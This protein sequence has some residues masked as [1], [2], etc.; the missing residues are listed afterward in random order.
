M[1]ITLNVPISISGDRELVGG[2]NESLLKH[3]FSKVLQPASINLVALDASVGSGNYTVL[4]AEGSSIGNVADTPVFGTN[5]TMSSNDELYIADT[6]ILKELWVHIITA[7]VFTADGIDLFDSTNGV[8]FNR[9][10]TGVVDHTDAFRNVGW[11]DIT[12]T[13]PA[14]AGVALALV[15]TSPDP[16]L[17]TARPWYKIKLRNFTTVTTAPVLARITPIFIDAEQKYADLSGLAGFSIT[18]YAG[19]PLIGLTFFPVVGDEVIITFANPARG[20]SVYAFRKNL[21]PADVVIVY[22]YL[23]SDNTWKALTSLAD[24][25]DNYRNGPAVLIEPPTH[26]DLSFATPT[27]WVEKAIDLPLTDGTTLTATGYHIRRRFAAVPNKSEIQGAVV[28]IRAKQYG[29]ANT[30]GIAVTARTVDRVAVELNGAISGAADAGV[31][32]VVNLSTG[33][34]SQFTVPAAATQGD[35]I[36]ASITTLSF[37]AGEMLGLER[38]SGGRTYS[39]LTVHI[40]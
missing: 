18:S 16:V 23:A 35:I 22:E 29:S 36:N 20:Y 33:A 27:D 37:L 38:V 8:T 24:E 17:N 10:L 14:T 39:D 2:A 32:Q 31:F 34:A 21:T 30:S 12:W 9:Q 3:Y 40:Q 6:K 19:S 13:Q 26:F 1:S 5:T 28:S 7:G 15:P 25:S 4:S 11:K